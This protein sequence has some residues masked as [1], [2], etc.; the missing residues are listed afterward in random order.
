MSKSI[1]KITSLLLAGGLVADVS[2][3][4]EESDITDASYSIKLVGT[5]IEYDIQCCT[6]KLVSVTVGDFIDGDGYH[7]FIDFEARTFETAVASIQ[8]HFAK[9]DFNNIT[10]E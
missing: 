5:E 3:N 9:T 1:D 4:P 8:E 10:A 2:Y 6:P 7:Q